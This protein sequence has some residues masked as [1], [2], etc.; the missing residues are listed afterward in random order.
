ML[1]LTFLSTAVAPMSDEE[2]WELIRSVRPKNEANDITGVMLYSDRSFIETIE[3]PDEAI[4][5]T[6]GRIA[7]DP[8]HRGM[9]IALREHITERAYPDWSMGFRS[10]SGEEMASLPGYNDYMEARESLLEHPGKPLHHHVFHRV[11]RDAW[12]YPGR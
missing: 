9:F 12:R 1:S 10:L 7:V 6:I 11:F 8:R 3:G 5:S 2:L 4:E